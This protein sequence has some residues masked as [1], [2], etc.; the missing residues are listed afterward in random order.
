MPESPVQTVPSKLRAPDGRHDEIAS[1]I[2]TIKSF[3][4]SSQD[5]QERIPTS[6]AHDEH[7]WLTVTDKYHKTLT[8]VGDS[9]ENKDE[10]RL[11]SMISALRQ[12]EEQ[13]DTEKNAA[14]DGLTGAWS[15]KSL[16]NYLET[17]RLKQ[18]ENDT[19]G[20]LLFDIDNFKSYNDTKGH[21]EGDRILRALANYMATQV[22][23]IDMVA[24]YGGEEFSIVLTS[25]P[26]KMIASAK[27]EEIRKGIAETLGITASIGVTVIQKHDEMIKQIYDRADAH[28]YQSKKDEG[29]NAVV[30]D[31][32]R[33][34][35]ITY[36]QR[37]GKNHIASVTY[38][39]EP[40]AASQ[41]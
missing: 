9:I 11:R 35:Q 16:D 7:Y 2:E 30:D 32:G 39:Q 14:T 13:V 19:T 20:F 34:E 4:Q 38:R 8:E 31:I 15:R 37:D 17:L 27:A 24:R 41:E 6:L 22:R 28:L 21:T 26:D 33:V 25:L 1:R 40:H 18:R 36:E 29:K 23:G 5:I 3:A 10:K 12:A